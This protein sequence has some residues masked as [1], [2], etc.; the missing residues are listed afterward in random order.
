MAKKQQKTT[1]HI[2]PTDTTANEAD[3]AYVCDSKRGYCMHWKKE[4]KT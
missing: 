1:V 4:H 3:S 2:Y